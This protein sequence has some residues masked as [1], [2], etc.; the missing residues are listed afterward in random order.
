MLSL[1]VIRNIIKQIKENIFYAILLD[2]TSDI[3]VKEQIS[4]CLR[5]V[6][7][8]SL[9]IEEYFM[10]QCFDGASNVSENHKGLQARIKEIEP[11]ALFVHCQ[12]HSLNLVTQDS[13]RNVKNARDTLNFIRE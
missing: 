8:E 1:E 10:E 7:K 4:F 6:D 11:R 5:T 9:E 2:K 3:T 12:A 13:M